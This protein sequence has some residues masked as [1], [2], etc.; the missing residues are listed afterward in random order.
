M[1]TASSFALSFLDTLIHPKA[2][3]T[4]YN[5]TFDLLFALRVSFN[6]ALLPNCLFYHL[7]LRTIV[8]SNPTSFQISGL[9]L[10]L[11]TPAWI[12]PGPFFLSL[13]ST[14]NSN[15]HLVRFCFPT[16]SLTV[17]RYMI[18]L[19]SCCKQHFYQ[20]FCHYVL[21]IVV[22]DKFLCYPVRRPMPWIL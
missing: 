21:W 4:Y 12:G 17:I 15:Q 8:P 19:Q 13:L 10:F 3:T 6:Q 2:L 22:F 1:G 7:V 11:F 20:M 5:H 16:S 9:P 14:I 18:C